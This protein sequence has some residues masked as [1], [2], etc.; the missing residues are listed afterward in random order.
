MTASRRYL[1]ASLACLLTLVAGSAGLAS[2]GGGSALDPYSYVPAPTSLKSNTK[3]EKGKKK[4]HIPIIKKA[5][6]EEKIVQQD[7]SNQ[8]QTYVKLPGGAKSKKQKETAFLPEPKKAK[9]ASA[10]TTTK[11]S[12]IAPAPEQK[13]AAL[14]S[15]TDDSVMGGI[16]TIGEGYSKTFKAASKGVVSSTKAASDAV[17]ASSKK[18]SD[19]IKSGAKA[20]GDVFMKGATMVSHG[21]KA[22]GEKIKDG[23]AP[24]TGKLAK[25]PAHAAPAA[26]PAA[27]PTAAPAA[28]PTVA[29]TPATAPKETKV[30]SEKPKEGGL[31]SKL[32]HLPKPKMPKIG[33][34][35][36]GGKKKPPV[37][38]RQAGASEQG[39]P[40]PDTNVAAAPKQT[41][42]E[43]TAAPKQTPI[44][45]DTPAQTAQAPAAAPKA[46][47]AKVSPTDKLKGAGQSL[48]T[49][50]G[51]VSKKIG[52]LWPF[53][54]KD[55][56]N[57]VAGKQTQPPL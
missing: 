36:V 40:A 20:S 10:L 7:D 12:D 29:A 27:A 19:S 39:S 32:A 38:D 30:A 8:S 45:D 15:K 57:D 33:I 34:P 9:A 22:T 52:K 55:N 14:A 5:Q 42:I 56:A 17:L 11:V 24:L 50:S 51:N 48:A 44:V 4:V 21:F 28:I 47:K 49:M 13:K 16:K 54:H 26:A 18:M 35:F 25:A 23:A 3:D 53:G 2:G 41:P 46:P 31:G 1:P 6:A 37:V 43:K